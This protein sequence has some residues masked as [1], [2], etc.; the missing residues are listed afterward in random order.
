MKL[1]HGSNTVVDVIDFSKSKPG[2]DFGKGFYLSADKKQ[3][4]DMAVFKT[5]ILGGTPIISVFKCDEEKLNSLKVKRFNGYSKEWAEFVFMNRTSDS[6]LPKHDY[7]VVIG[8]IANDKVG[9]QIRYY[10]DKEIDFNTFLKR[11]KYM[12]GETIQYFFGT[13]ESLAALKFDGYEQ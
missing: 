5:R 3:A 1:Y 11:L 7:D 2:K 9:I 4:S 8:P 13:P 10:M 6:E 12:K